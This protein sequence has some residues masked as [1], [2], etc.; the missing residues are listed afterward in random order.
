[1]QTRGWVG[2]TCGYGLDVK[3]IGSI[4][5]CLYMGKHTLP[6]MLWNQTA[7]Y[8][9]SHL[10]ALQVPLGTLSYLMP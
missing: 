4:E 8:K 7:T 9:A 10:Y 3:Q 6:L 1:M 5:A 2:C